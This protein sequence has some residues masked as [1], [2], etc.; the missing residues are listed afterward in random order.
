M[1]DRG[2]RGSKIWYPDM[3]FVPFQSFNEGKTYVES[4]LAVAI[5]PDAR[6]QNA[7]GT[8]VRS[9]VTC[10]YDLRAQRVVNVV[11]SES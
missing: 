7:G 8:L 3:A 10:T 4:G 11:V 5:E 1:Q 2:N 6:F 9:R